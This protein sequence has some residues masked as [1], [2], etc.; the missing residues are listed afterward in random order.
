MPASFD[1]SSLDGS[2]LPSAV[3]GPPEPG[4][5]RQGAGRVQWANAAWRRLPAV[6]LDYVLDPSR[7]NSIRSANVLTLNLRSKF[8]LPEDAPLAIQPL[9][10]HA[11]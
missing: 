5:A 1:F 9:P 3:I 4:D 8:D 11:V 10:D 6:L 2:P 7:W